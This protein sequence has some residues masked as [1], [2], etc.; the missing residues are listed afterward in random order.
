YDKINLLGS[1]IQLTNLKKYYS[2]ESIK[3]SNNR[4]RQFYGDINYQIAEN[5]T[6]GLGAR[7]DLSRRSPN[8]LTRTIRVTY[9]KDCVRITTKIYSDYLADGSRGIKK[10]TSSPTISIGLKVLNM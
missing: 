9:A 4:V 5:W 10:T 1:F 6:I 7:I 3:I 8:L 2:V